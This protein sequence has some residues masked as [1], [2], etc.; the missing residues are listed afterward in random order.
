MVN[1][2]KATQD[3][4]TDFQ[5]GSAARTLLESSAIEVEELYHRVLSGIL[6]AIPTSIYKA[7][8]F[9]L[10]GAAAASGAVHIAFGTA[11]VDAFTIPAGTT[12]VAGTLN[13]T[14][15][16]EQ[17][18]PIG[19][20]S[21][22]VVVACSTLG[23]IG[24]VAANAITATTGYSFPA[25]SVL[26]NPAFSSGNDGQTESE[27][28]ARFAEYIQSLSRGTTNSI[29]YAVNQ[30]RVTN[31]NGD[32]IE[33]VA[34]AGIAEIPGRVDVYVYGSAG[35]P[36]ADLLTAADQIVNGYRD[37]A[38]TAV[39]G[40]VAGGVEGRVLSMVER[41]IDVTLYMTLSAGVVGTDALKN[42]LAT[43]LDAQF[44]SVAS[45]S[46]LQVAQLTNAAL[47]LSGALKAVAANTENVVC[48]AGEVLKLGAL[49]VEWSNA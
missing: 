28:K 45:S 36:S 2:M 34:R 1:Q 49:V 21:V 9:E 46:T 43:L 6:D 11:I 3:R 19:A 38:G 18:V 16:A 24:N 22:D 30:A 32:I 29:L 13:F 12:F 10:V 27:R 35:L 5:V 42:Q 40:Y 20:T 23:S 14:S 25:G 39:P 41:A 47:T 15:L 33:Y 31:A 26:G 4:V 8:D 7:F 17:L 48:G 37:N 44:D